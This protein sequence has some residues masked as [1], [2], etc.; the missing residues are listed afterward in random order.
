MK[1]I[2]ALLTAFCLLFSLLA[3]SGCDGTDKDRTEEKELSVVATIFPLYDWTKTLIGEEAD[4]IDL[5]LL[6]D[7]GVDLHNYQP[8]AKDLITL[9]NCDLL[10]AIGGESD[11]WL[12]DLPLR[13]DGTP[14]RVLRLLDRLGD[15]VKEEAPVGEEEHDH[16]YD[17]DEEEK[18]EHVWL[19]LRLA[20]LA[21]REIGR[22]LSEVDPAAKTVYEKNLAEYTDALTRLDDRYAEAVTAGT[23]KALLFADRFPFRYLVDDYGLTYDAAFSG[24]SAETEASFETVA[25]LA[26]RADEWGLSYV[27]TLEGSDGKL[28]GTVIANTKTKNQGVLSF[29]S[30]QSTTRADADGGVTYL[31]VMEKNLDALTAALR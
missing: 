16:E 14:V 2:F 15:E 27:L 31:S 5:T 12:D 18:D 7:S 6:L 30:M 8:T 10:L 24:C 28:A 22:E 21:C 9:T 13:P 4:R 20:K 17:H 19:S 1:R 11:R 26:K 3:L 29:D 23:K 25:R